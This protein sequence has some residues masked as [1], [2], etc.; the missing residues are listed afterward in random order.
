MIEDDEALEAQIA[1]L[2]R[3]E[4]KKAR[5]YMPEADMEL[6][7][8]QSGID[9]PAVAAAAQA[10]LEEEGAMPPDDVTETTEE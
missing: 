2:E 9:D 3:G 5:R 1:A 6:E 7:D 4:K 8:A 10:I